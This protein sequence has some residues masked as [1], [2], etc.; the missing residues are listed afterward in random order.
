[1]PPTDVYLHVGLI[2]TGTT[3]LQSRLRADLDALQGQGLSVLPA[4]LHDS[5][6]LSLAVKDAYDP[7]VD[8]PQGAGALERF[9]E[10]VAAAETP[11]VL[12][13]AETL[14]GSASPEQIERLGGLLEG[15]RLHVVLTVRDLARAVPSV[16]QQRVRGGSTKTF[17]SYVD[18]AV[19]GPRSE[20]R[21]RGF[22]KSQDVLGILERWGTLAPPERCHVVVLPPRGAPRDAL[23]E[24]FC[25]VVE[26]DP[27]QLP[28]E[29]AESVGRAN[30]SLGLAQAEVL[31]RMNALVPDEVGRRDTRRRFVKKQIG[32]DVLAGL[33]G[34]PPR[35]PREFADALRTQA[36]TMLKGIEAAGYRLVGDPADLI[37]ADSSFADD[38]VAADSDEVADAAV[39]ALAAVVDQQVGDFIVRKARTRLRAEKRAERE[40]AKAAKAAAR[41][42][43]AAAAA[44]APPPPTGLRARLRAKAARLLRR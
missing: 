29:P 16:W 35:V 39:A 18:A 17:A 10:E 32:Y 12:F 1:M 23:F 40:A 36:E 42:A 6:L 27:A 30:E 19:A 20:G 34:A 14:A 26:V 2:K 13:S 38:P 3:Y 24:R 8:L 9:P 43:A 33:A 11:R 37:P 41:E 25:S 31:R 7:D 22:W 28:D 21:Q 15:Y 4:D 44:A 5:H